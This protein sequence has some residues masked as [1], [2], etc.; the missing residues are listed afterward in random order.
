MSKNKRTSRAKRSRTLDRAAI[1]KAAAAHAATIKERLAQR[2]A[3]TAKIDVA[4]PLPVLHF[5][6]NL[7]V[8]P[9]LQVPDGKDFWADVECVAAIIAALRDAYRQGCREGYIEGFVA[10]REPDRRR[11]RTAN[12]LKRKTRVHLPDGRTM[13]RDER[14]VLMLA[15]YPVLL[16]LMKPTPAKQRLAGKYG[17]ESWQGVDAVI[18][19]SARKST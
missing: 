11:S 18:K 2:A 17:F 12:I 15:E 8:E 13:T 4:I 19:R 3:D 14:D 16:E 5:L 9:P 1:L 6:E 7:Y 10:R